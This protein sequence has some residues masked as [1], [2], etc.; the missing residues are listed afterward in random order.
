M[1]DSHVEYFAAQLSGVHRLT[2]LKKNSSP[3]GT[4]EQA[5][6]LEISE[7]WVIVYFPFHFLHICS[8]FNYTQAIYCNMVQGNC[9]HNFGMQKSLTILRNFDDNWLQSR[10][11]I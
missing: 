11:N 4:F 7:N 10:L 5:V 8:N 6:S 1:Y 2:Q 9:I 3:S